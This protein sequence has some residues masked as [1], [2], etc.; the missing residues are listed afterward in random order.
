MRFPGQVRTFDRAIPLRVR[1]TLEKAEGSVV[2]AG[3]TVEFVTPE[4]QPVLVVCNAQ[5][6]EEEA[7]D[8]TRTIEGRHD[9]PAARNNRGSAYFYLGGAENARRALADHAGFR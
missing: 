2:D 4:P 7:D 5:G 3:V 9:D 6:F 1:L 8:L